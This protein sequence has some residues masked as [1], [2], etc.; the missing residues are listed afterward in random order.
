MGVISSRSIENAYKTNIIT[1][2]LACDQEPDHSTIAAFVSSNDKAIKELFSQILL[3]CSELG[4][5]KGDMFAIDGCKLSSNASKEWSGTLE[6]LKKKQEDLRKLSEKIVRQHRQ[7]DKRESKQKKLNKT[8]RAYVY[9]KEYQKKHIERIEKKLAK[10]TA[11]LETAE[12]KTGIGG[13]EIQS[14]ITDKESA[15]IKGPHGYIQGYNGIA[16]A[17][18][19]NQVIVAAEAV[20]SGPETEQFPIILNELNETMKKLTGKKEPL[21]KKVI[22][23]DTGYFSEEN[24]QEAENSKIDPIIPDPQFRQRDPQFDG[25]KGHREKKRFT[26]EDFIYNPGDNTYTCPAGKTLAYKGKVKLN[27]SSGDKWMADSKDCASCKL[28]GNCIAARNADAPHPRRT[29]FISDKKDKKNLSEKMRKKID[30]PVYRKLYG[31]RM[32]IIEPCFSDITYCK[33]MDRFT[34]RGKTKVNIQWLIFCIVH[35][36]GKC[37]RPLAARYG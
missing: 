31:R 34:L 21:K 30:D 3:Q 27:R 29:L 36:I 15:K 22:A 35:N 37:I 18:S 26:A 14:N 24:L 13:Q 19:E 8:C 23:C 25:R 28:R 7:M 17:D 11:F 16:A 20:G 6:E 1:K 10:I 9:D 33:G 4:L 2:A 32:Q 12:A 5:V